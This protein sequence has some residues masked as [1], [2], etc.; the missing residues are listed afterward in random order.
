MNL[1]SGCP[2][3]SGNGRI[4]SMKMKVVIGVLIVIAVVLLVVFKSPFDFDGSQLTEVQVPDPAIEAR[5]EACYAEKDHEI[6]SRAFATI[7]NPDV[8]REYIT[9]NRAIARE[10]CRAEFPRTLISE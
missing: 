5:Y 6:H 3:P 4:A 2:R 10:E 8:Q 1:K 7:D 9:A